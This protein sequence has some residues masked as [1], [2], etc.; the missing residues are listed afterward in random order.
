MVSAII[1]TAILIALAIC[2]ALIILCAGEFRRRIPILLYHRIRPDG[3]PDQER[4]YLVYTSAFEEQMQY[5]HDEGYSTISLY[6]LQAYIQEGKE[7]PEKPIILTFDDGYLSTYKYAYP[8]MRKYGF[9][10]TVFVTSDTSAKVFDSYRSFDPPLT[11]EQV[12]ELSENGFS[13]Q[14]HSV[15][16]RPMTELTAEQITWELSESKK[17]LEEIIGTP[18]EFLAMPLGFYSK[19]VKR[20]SKKLGYKAVIHNAKGTN[21][22]KS[23]LHALRR[24]PVER[25]FDLPAFIKSFGRVA[26]CQ[27][28]VIGRVKEIPKLVLSPSRYV[29]LRDWLQTSWLG[30][31]TTFQGVKIILAAFALFLLAIVAIIYFSS[32]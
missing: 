3:E 32:V 5:L 30:Y 6:E 21:N 19:T 7:L 31:F 16:H 15:T 23:D 25:D 18:V 9:T 28:R 26:A 11:K 17:Q 12:R 4:I 10:A 8:I 1:I 27:W 14:A 22:S 24:I 20:I 13:I 29:K 2:V